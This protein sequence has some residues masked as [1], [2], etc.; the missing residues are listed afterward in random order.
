MGHTV[1]VHDSK[2]F[3]SLNEK[4]RLVSSHQSQKEHNRRENL[5]TDLVMYKDIREAFIEFITWRVHEIPDRVVE[6]IRCMDE[7]YMDYLLLQEAL[8]DPR[9]EA[10]DLILRHLHEFA[11]S[12]AY[13]D[14]F[15]KETYSSKTPLTS[16]S[17]SQSGYFSE[18]KSRF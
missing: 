6:I 1:S 18:S 11:K 17:H 14:A 5:R 15:T 13:D 16:M 3:E 10:T 7:D 2:D 8:D 4:F 12:S 9:D